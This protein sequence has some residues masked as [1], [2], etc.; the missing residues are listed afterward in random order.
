MNVSG[1]IHLD[2]GDTIALAV[3]Q[4]SGNDLQALGTGQQTSLAL[5][6]LSP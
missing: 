1:L 6:F 5:Q 4:G 2:A 3:R